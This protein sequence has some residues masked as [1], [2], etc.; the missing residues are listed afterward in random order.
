MRACAYVCVRVHF[1]LPLTEQKN[2]CNARVHIS[3]SKLCKY[4]YVKDL[5]LRIKVNHRKDFEAGKCT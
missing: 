4:F 5:C 3:N 1:F 2:N